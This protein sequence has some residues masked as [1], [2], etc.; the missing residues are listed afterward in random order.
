[1]ALIH[2][3]IRA[4]ITDRGLSQMAAAKKCDIVNRTLHSAIEDER[5]V[6]HDLLQKISDGLQIDFGYFSDAAPKVNL[7][8]I[9]DRDRA[10]DQALKA[11]RGSFEKACRTAAYDGNSI[12][13]QSFLDWWCSTSGRLENFDLIAPKLDIF[14]PPEPD[15]NIINPIQIGSDSLATKS[16][17]SQHVDHLKQTLLGFSRP[18]N[19]KLVDAHLEALQ[20][21]EPVIT[22]PAL[23]EKL[24][25]GRRFSRQYRRVLAPVVAENRTLI[26]NYSEDILPV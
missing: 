21:G 16:F 8:P 25:D 4:A 12:T 11:L 23:D 17:S 3:K 1:M 14:C 18:C 10:V 6:S 2:E 24:R 13:L 15:S 9:R 22:H 20:R 19:R 5:K 26:V 7:E